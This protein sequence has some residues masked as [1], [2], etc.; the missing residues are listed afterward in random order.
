MV[1]LRPEA[2]FSITATRKADRLVLTFESK[3]DAIILSGVK[4]AEPRLGTTSAM[5]LQG[6]VLRQSCA[7]LVG[8]LWAAPA[9]RPRKT[10][11]ST[12]SGALA[13]DRSGSRANRMPLIAS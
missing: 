8:A 7:W 9:A 2:A 11:S 13:L 1:H 10:S 3:F 4:V 6:W 5:P 12:D